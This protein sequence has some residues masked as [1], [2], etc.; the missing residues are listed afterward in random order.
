MK[1]PITQTLG[2]KGTTWVH[3]GTRNTELCSRLRPLVNVEIIIFL[4]EVLT[5]CQSLL[6]SSVI[7]MLSEARSMAA[8]ARKR[9]TSGLQMS[10]KEA[11]TIFFNSLFKLAAYVWVDR[12][13]CYCCT[14]YDVTP[15]L[16]PAR[17][18]TTRSFLLE[19]EEE[20]ERC[21]C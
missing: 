10:V 9:V 4:L 17:R 5:L 12:G 6:V 1:S 3:I 2:S 13:F 19:K 20:T 11:Q 7:Q 14:S 16:K 18:S 8:N 21:S 15:A